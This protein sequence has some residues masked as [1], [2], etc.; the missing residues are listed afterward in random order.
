M[1]RSRSSAFE[2]ITRSGAALRASSVP[3][4]FRSWSTSVVLPWST[5]AMMATLR[6]CAAGFVLTGRDRSRPLRRGLS[7]GID[8]TGCPAASVAGAVFCAAATC[9]PRPAPRTSGL[10]LHLGDHLRRHGEVIESGLVGAHR[11]LGRIG[12]ADS[13]LSNLAPAPLT[14]VRPSIPVTS[15]S[16]V[17]ACTRGSSASATSKSCPGAGFAGRSYLRSTPAAVLPVADGSGEVRV[18]DVRRRLGRRSRLLRLGLGLGGHGRS[19]ILAPPPQAASSR[20]S[21]DATG[22]AARRKVFAV[23]CRVLNR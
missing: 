9:R 18:A 21:A 20:A 22:A 23:M 8:S 19:G 6:S 1:P 4:C 7:A 11:D 13:T 17:S 12:L 2:S 5:C 10:G 15:T 16:R 14:I 3:D